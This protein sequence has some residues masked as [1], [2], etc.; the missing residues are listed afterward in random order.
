M[1]IENAPYT[2]AQLDGGERFCQEL[3]A[4]VELAMLRD[5]VFRVA[6]D[7]QHAHTCRSR[8]AHSPPLR[9]RQ[10]RPED[11]ERSHPARARSH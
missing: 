4:C 8:R 2:C 7:V 6:G 11:Y 3:D 10:G 9:G 5:G 1:A